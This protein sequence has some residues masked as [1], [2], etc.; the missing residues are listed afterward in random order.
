VQGLGLLP[1]LSAQYFAAGITMGVSVAAASSVILS[2]WWVRR[3]LHRWFLEPTEPRLTI[4]WLV[5]LAFNLSLAALFLWAATYLLTEH[6]LGV[7]APIK[8][9]L[10][11]ST[12]AAVAFFGFLSAEVEEPPKWLST[13]NERLVGTSRSLGLGHVARWV[14]RPPFIRGVEYLVATPLVVLATVSCL[15]AGFL[16]FSNLPQEFGGAHPSCVQLDI[17]RT[18]MSRETQEALLPDQAASNLKVARTIRLDLLFAG[19]DSVYVRRWR[20]DRRAPKDLRVYTV[21][22]KLV[23]STADCE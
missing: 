4:R 21:G 13:A 7:S 1:V 15:P 8:P 22:S 12:I 6:V 19:G 20:D 9:P 11:F 16:A 2:P 23:A 5:A 3:R 18:M 10:F 17:D 14:L